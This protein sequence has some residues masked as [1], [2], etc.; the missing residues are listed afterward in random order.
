[1][2]ISFIHTQILVQL[3]VNKTSFHMKGFAPGLALKQR[4]KATRKSPILLIILRFCP[5]GTYWRKVE[6]STTMLSSGDFLRLFKFFFAYNVDHGLSP[7]VSGLKIVIS[8]S[9]LFKLVHSMDH[10][11]DLGIESSEAVSTEIVAMQRKCPLASHNFCLVCPI[12]TLDP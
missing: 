8:F 12:I 6:S 2:E 3:Q 9:T 1:M 10:W 7:G 5:K 11:P 4:R